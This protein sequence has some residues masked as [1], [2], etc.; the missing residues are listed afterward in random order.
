VGLVKDFK[1]K[2]RLMRMES[3]FNL[4]INMLSQFASRVYKA[5]AK[6]KELE[7]RMDQNS[8]KAYEAPVESTKEAQ[9]EPKASA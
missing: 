1:R 3:D 6:C 9:A 8:L 2:S 7:A 5:E 4:A